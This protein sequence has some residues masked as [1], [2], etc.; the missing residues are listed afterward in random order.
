[1]NLFGSRKRCAF[2]LGVD[3]KE[4]ISRWANIDT[5]FIDPQIV[6]TGP[7]LDV[8]HRGDEVDLATLP[9]MRHFKEDGGRYVTNGIFVAKDPETGVR[10][11]SF[12]RMQVNG[13]NRFGTS[14]HSRR[15]LWNYCRKAVEMGMDRL[16]VAVVIGCHPLITFGTALWKG[17][18]DVDEYAVAGG[19]L[20]QPLQ[21]VRG[22][23]VPVE[24]P[25]HAEIVIEGFL[26]LNTNEP[27]GPFGEFTGYASE[28]ST[29]H[30]LEVT[31]VCHRN[32]AIY[33]SIVAGMSDEHNL[34]TAIGQEARQLKSLRV[35]YPNV[36]AVSYPKSGT[37]LL[38]VYVSIKDAAP[39]QA[40]N[41]AAAAMSDN[42]SAKLAV[43]VDDDVDV[44][45]EAEVIWAI[46]TRFQADR[47]LD[48]IRNAMGAIL[49]P[50]N[51]NGLTSKLIID[52]TRKGP[53]FPRRHSLP[54][55]SI[56]MAQAFIDKISD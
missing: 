12:H 1:M 5:N 18:I 48:V 14:L 43:I 28:R 2:A 22:V 3:E 56:K 25:A 50:S 53:S 26:L 51:Y 24:F 36:T 34:L 10:N 30:A 20:G 11:A 35:Q 7:I 46:A 42:L 9:I 32:D 16:P 8:V 21:I 31:A 33:Q 52:A 44:Y 15:H 49:D 47:D 40:R 29:N 39:G 37:G 19:F 6:E 38:H 55:N 13:K 27:E 45:N 17:P 54:E 41:I 4:L 23:T